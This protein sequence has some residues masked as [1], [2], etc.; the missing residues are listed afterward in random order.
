MVNSGGYPPLLA[1]LRGIVV[2]DSYWLFSFWFLLFA[3]FYDNVSAISCMYIY[4]YIYIYIS[5]KNIKCC[6]DGFS[7]QEVN[8]RTQ[9]KRSAFLRANH[10]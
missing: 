7:K 6:V 4:I 5:H 1:D 9:M 2:L 10:H 3:F 8:N